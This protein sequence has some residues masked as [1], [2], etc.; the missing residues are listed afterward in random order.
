MSVVTTLS[1]LGRTEEALNFYRDALGAETLFLMRFRDC[2]DKSHMQP[3]MEEMIFHASFQIDGT[4]FMAS[5]VGY[6]EQTRTPDFAGF[7]LL[8]S[9]ESIE[10]A[11][12]MFAALSDGGQVVVPLAES[13]FTAWYGIVIDKLGVSW[14]VSVRESGG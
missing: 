9:P 5:D 7:A 3:G 11:K 6:S 13:S 2:P 8:L 10:R 12:Q 4:E 14:K 1:F